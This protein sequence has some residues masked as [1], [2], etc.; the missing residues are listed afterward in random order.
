MKIKLKNTPEQVELIKAIGSKNRT[1][2]IEAQDIFAEFI[3]PVIQKVLDQLSTVSSIYSNA[4]YDEDSNPSFPLDLYY[5]VNQAGYVSVW[6]Q[7]MA[8]GLPRSEDV[9]PTEELKLHTYRLDTAV[10]LKR[11][12]FNRARLDIV[13]RL[14]NRM[15]QE[16]LVKQ[17]RNGWAVIMKALA[18]ATTNTTRNL[19]KG[20]GHT[21]GVSATYG[22]S[23]QHV[24]Q[25]ATNGTFQ[26][27]DL[28]SLITRIKRIN[29]SWNGGSAVEPY[30]RGITD[31]YVSPEIKQDIRA[32]AYNP[33]STLG[34]NQ[35]A[36]PTSNSAN[37]G[38]ALPD[39]I[40][41]SIFNSAGME[42]IFGVNI[43]DLNEL[44]VGQKYDRLFSTFA[45]ATT[46]G[47]SAFT[48]G[49]D[50]ILVGIDNSREA[51]IRPVAEQAE[52]GGQFVTFPDDQFSVRSEEIGFYGYVEEGHLCLDARAVAGIIV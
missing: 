34:A 39:S 41:E 5:N 21:S 2:S 31:L 49:T 3:G 35:Q 6:S 13:G 15:A 38:I 10:S 1:E 43:V 17:E 14:L 4:P 8:G 16:V 29:S 22:S 33:M 27:A 23:Y 52:S 20:L 30:S 36:V 50:E 7:T 18:E 37:P 25:S 26:L 44:G 9:Q 19:G 48:Q 45:G 51:F 12:F 47:G 46:Y 24:I 40:R 28:S 42:G 11:K 32:F